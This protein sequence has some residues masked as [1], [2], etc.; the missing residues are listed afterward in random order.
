MANFILMQRYI[1]IYPSVHKQVDEP[2][3]FREATDKDLVAILNVFSDRETI[4]NYFGR[5]L[6]AELVMDNILETF[7]LMEKKLGYSWIISHSVT[8]SIIGYASVNFGEISYCIDKKF[9]RCGYGT[10]LI[11]L[12]LDALLSSLVDCSME[13]RAY[14]LRNNIWSVQLLESCE[15]R[16][17]GLTKTT[18]F[19][20]VSLHYTKLLST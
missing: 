10:R 12:V 1:N 18:R 13:I 17:M 5:D 6:T 4:Y 14:V 15:F 9:R 3:V 16:F 20:D 2:Y 11:K 8:G 7:G 19:S